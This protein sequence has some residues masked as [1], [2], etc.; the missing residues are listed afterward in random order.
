MKRW[1][2]L[3]VA[4]LALVA[5]TADASFFDF[6]QITIDATAGGKGFTASKITPTGKP[7]ITTVSCRLETAEVRFLVLDPVVTAVTASVGT[8]LEPG[9]Y[10]AITSREE[11]LNFRAIRTGATSGTLSCAYKSPSP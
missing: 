9:D 4:A 1:L 11:I 7:A 6:E 8:L 10:L 5:T 3:S 2:V